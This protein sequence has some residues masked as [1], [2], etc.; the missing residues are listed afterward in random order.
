MY[1]ASVK[2]IYIN[3]CV[4]C[5]HLHRKDGSVR[6]TTKS[7]S[8]LEPSM[9]NNTSQKVVLVTGCSY[10][11]GCDIAKT[12]AA[13]EQKRYKVW[14]TVRALDEKDTMETAAG[15]LLN[16]TLFIKELDLTKPQS[17]EEA[18]RQIL[19]EDGHVDILINNAVATTMGAIEVIDMDR[20]R[21]AFEV[22]FFGHLRLMQLIIPSMKSRKS[23]RIINISSGSCLIASPFSDCYV[24]SKVALEGLSECQASVLRPFNIWVSVV[25]LSAV[26]TKNAIDIFV[27]GR[28][29][30]VLV[31][32]NVDDVT[33]KMQDK[34]MEFV[35]QSLVGDHVKQPEEAADFILSVAETDSPSFRYQ[36]AADVQY[37]AS[38]RYC[39]PSGDSSVQ[40]AVQIITK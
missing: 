13:D 19:D 5:P 12:F 26:C 21:D 4:L 20:V 34:W 40:N 9:A 30:K 31:N 36:S 3:R 2:Y 8:L 27:N 7:K 23:G 18:A 15:S 6:V 33:K 29:E 10:G 1:I 16:E 11:L 14:A 38:A 22:N 39:Q 17:I 24:A 37:L 32:G 25:Q 35:K 28:T